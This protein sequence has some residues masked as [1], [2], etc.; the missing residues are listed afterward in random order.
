MLLRQRDQKFLQTLQVDL[1]CGGQLEEN[2]AEAFLQSFDLEHEFLERLF[3]ILQFAI[4]RDVAAGLDGK[5]EIGW[6]LIAP[7]SLSFGGGQAV[8]AVVDF[9]GVETIGIPAQHAIRAQIGRIERSAPMLVV[10]A[11]SSDV[12]LT[13][14]RVTGWHGLSWMGEVVEMMAGH[15]WSKNECG[16]FEIELCTFAGERKRMGRAAFMHPSF[17]L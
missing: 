2:R 13:E 4:V 16:S 8:K 15:S 7:S 14:S 6:R 11:R 17:F 9:Y 5:T 1:P 3:G 10:P 12:N